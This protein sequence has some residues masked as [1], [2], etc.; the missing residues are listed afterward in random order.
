MLYL[1]KIQINTNI[2]PGI[3]ENYLKKIKD[4]VTFLPKKAICILV[5]VQILKKV[6]FKI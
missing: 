4:N 5:S 3:I 6:T 1:L 2:G